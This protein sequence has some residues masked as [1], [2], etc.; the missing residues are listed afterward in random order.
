MWLQVTKK[1]LLMGLIVV[2]ASLVTTPAAAFKLTV[3]NQFDKQKSISLLYF[4]ESV[5]KWLCVGWYN[6]LAGEEREI[7]L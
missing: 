4:D 5:E 1:W 3:A 7:L 6:V 2:A